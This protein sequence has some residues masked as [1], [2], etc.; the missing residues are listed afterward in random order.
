[1]KPGSF[2]M[3]GP[4]WA[5]TS[6]CPASSFRQWFDEG[7]AEWASGGW[8]AGEGWR[9]RVAFA[10][11][12]APPLDSLTLG[13]PRDRASAELA[14]LLSATAVEYLIQESGERGLRLFLERWRDEGKLRHRHERRLRSDPGPVRGGLEGVRP[15][16]VRMALRPLPFLGVLAYPRLGPSGAWFGSAGGGTGRPWPG[17]GR[18]SLP[19]NPPTGKRR[20]GNKARSR[21]G[22][23]KKVSRTRTRDSCPNASWW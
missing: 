14:Y 18:E 16:T 17:S 19:T 2:G 21:C 8:S 5:S 3:N 9:L 22:Q 1:M 23:Q 4:T 6:T 15:E 11:G 7:Y 20:G 13:W 10:L 12:K